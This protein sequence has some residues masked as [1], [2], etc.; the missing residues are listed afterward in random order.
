[1][2]MTATRARPPQ[3]ASSDAVHWS[4]SGRC[5]PANADWFIRDGRTLSESN[6]AALMLCHSPCPV[7]DKCEAN[8]RGLDPQ[9]RIM[10]IAGGLVTDEDGQIIDPP[11]PKPAAKPAANPV[12]ECRWCHEQFT[13]RTN[14]LY[15]T[16]ACRRHFQRFA[17]TQEPPSYTDDEAATLPKCAG[18][19]TPYKPAKTQ[20]RFCTPACRWRTN[21]TRREHTGKPLGRRPTTALDGLK[22]ADLQRA[23]VWDPQAP[24][25]SVA[26]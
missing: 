15:C 17:S 6:V 24:G 5:G 18:C 7:K 2:G 21:N 12:R 26:S 22:V 13:G 8:L 23:G 11:M 3:V 16:T 1:M 14:Q 4:R 19:K 9:N 25:W 20:Q 10:Q